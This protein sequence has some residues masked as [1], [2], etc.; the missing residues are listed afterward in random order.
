MSQISQVHLH[1]VIKRDRGRGHLSS[2]PPHVV[3]TSG[4]SA[5]DEW[6]LLSS[7][8]PVNCTTFAGAAVRFDGKCRKL[9]G[10][11]LI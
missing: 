7:F 3:V 9:N 2:P 11:Q 6:R 5:V 8:S 10:H 1:S 4:L